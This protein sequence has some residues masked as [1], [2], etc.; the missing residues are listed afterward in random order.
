M[1]GCGGPERWEP[2]FTFHGFRY[3][4]VTHPVEADRLLRERLPRRGRRRRR[5]GQRRARTGSPAPARTPTTS[6][7]SRPAARTGT[8]PT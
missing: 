1:A 2:Q 8:S 4:E 7:R 6:S 5:P 3:A